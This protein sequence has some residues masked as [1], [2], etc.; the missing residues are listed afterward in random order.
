MR[1]QRSTPFSGLSNRAIVRSARTMAGRQT[2]SR[3]GTRCG[4]F[5]YVCTV[6]QLLYAFEHT[7]I[8]P[9][10]NQIQLEVHSRK[11]FGPIV[12]RFDH[13]AD[14]EFWEL[15]VPVEASAG[16]TG[17][18]V[19]RVQ[20]A[21]IKWI[22]ANARR[23]PIAPLY[24]QYANP[25]LG[26]STAGVPFR[27]SLHRASLP[28]NSPLCGRIMRRP[29]APA[30]LEQQRAARL[31]IACQRKFPKLVKW[32]QD[33]CARTVL[34]LEEDDL[35]LTNHFRVA[36]ALVPAE[37]ARPDAPDEVFLLSTCIEQTW[38]VIC[39]RMTAGERLPFRE[40]DPRELTRTHIAVT[41]RAA[42]TASATTAS[43]PARFEPATSSAPAN[44]SPRPIEAL[45]LAR[46][47][48][49]YGRL[50][51][52]LARVQLLILDDWGCRSLPSR[53]SATSSRSSKTVISALRRSSPARFRSSNGARSSATLR[54]LTQ[55]LTASCTTPTGSR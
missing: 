18:E 3:T 41:C 30:N 53:S 23:I 34:V 55:F 32:K 13:R 14:Q 51:K 12:E 27:F 54:S 24:E 39:L 45:A 5:D 29:F 16:L 2:T 10:S 21:F 38:W 52:A 50:L 44:C 49:R 42:S 17:G 43:S 37:A 36:D 47:D 26:E 15:H 28:S 46:G 11:L 7:G 4:E 40:F 25:S 6:G 31:Q 20:D 9:F 48:G 22:K 8:E 1:A 35:S 33:S 19:G